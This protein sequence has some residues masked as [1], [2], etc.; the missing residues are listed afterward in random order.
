MGA[1]WG[2]ESKEGN[3]L[4]VHCHMNMPSRK[5][6]GM[7]W[8][9]GYHSCMRKEDRRRRP[10]AR[11][12]CRAACLPAQKAAAQACSQ[13]AKHAAKEVLPH[14]LHHAQ[15]LGSHEKGAGRSVHGAVGAVAAR[16][17]ESK[18]KEA[19]CGCQ[20]GALLR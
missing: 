12:G 9:G 13:V 6:I 3:G 14:I 19:M 4:P 5:V 7:H 2:E 20:G 18:G 10:T 17:E 15:W 16:S 11:R 1:S 8:V